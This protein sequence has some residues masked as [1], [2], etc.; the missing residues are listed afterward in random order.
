[1]SEREGEEGEAGVGSEGKGFSSGNKACSEG[2]YNGEGSGGGVVGAAGDTIEGRQRFGQN[3]FKPSIT[4]VAEV[5]A[6]A[7]EIVE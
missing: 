2:L 4:V 6:A 5:S 1:M 3:F 7:C